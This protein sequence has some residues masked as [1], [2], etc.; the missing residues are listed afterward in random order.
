M[1]SAN[2]RQEVQHWAH[3]F[4]F[5][6]RKSLSRMTG[7]SSFRMFPTGSSNEFQQSSRDLAIRRT[8]RFLA[9]VPRVQVD[10]V[11]DA[12]FAGEQDQRFDIVQIVVH[13][14]T[15]QMYALPFVDAIP[16][17]QTQGFHAA[18]PRTG[19]TALGVVPGGVA[20]TRS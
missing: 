9:P 7:R 4:S 6:T 17:E 19:S 13:Q 10:H 1:L 11:G 14:H 18:L 15:D 12:Q 20:S 8:P 16:V 2:P 5:C 3:G